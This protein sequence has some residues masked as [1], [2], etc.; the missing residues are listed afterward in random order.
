MGACTLWRLSSRGV[1]AVGFERLQPGHDQGASHGETRIIR[2][3]YYEGAEYVPLVQEAFGLWRELEAASRQRLLT[4]TGALMIGNPES[5]L[6]SGALR[7]ARE[8]RLEHEL[9]NRDEVGKRFPQHR[10][11]PGEVALFEQQAGVL[12]PEACVVA[13]VHAAKSHGAEV[14]AG[15]RVPDIERLA[16]TYDHVVVCAGAWLT[17]LL[18]GFAL[19]VERQ[20]M[21]WFRP[22]DVAEFRPDRFPVFMRELPTGRSRFGIPAMDGDLVKVG[23]H[24]EGGPADPDSIDRDIH[25]SDRR[26]VEDFVA[27]ALPGLEPRVAKAKVCMYSNTPDH[28]FLVGPAPGFDNVTVLGGF[29]GH[30]FKFASVLG[31]VAA[32]LATEGRTRYA[33]ELFAP[34]RALTRA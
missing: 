30:G 13:A 15:E 7:S 21:T 5:E 14:R 28:H 29:S 18:P 16:A 4:I 20:A 10:L 26:P 17:K 22:R 2:T 19:E 9:L 11:R 12:R 31:D 24:H 33:I 1:P 8:H 3:A 23:I 25:D 6:V 32:D 27:E 34:T